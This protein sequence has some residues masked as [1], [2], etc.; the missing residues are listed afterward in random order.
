MPVAMSGQCSDRLLAKTFPRRCCKFMAPFLPPAT[1]LHLLF[2]AAFQECCNAACSYRVR[3]CVR[4]WLAKNES[5][6]IISGLL[7]LLLFVVVASTFRLASKFIDA[8]DA[9]LAG[10][11]KAYKKHRGHN[12]ALH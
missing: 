10:A 12:Y 8:D 9:K 6:A 7:L 5:V 1:G 3:H 4:R 11:F 2:L